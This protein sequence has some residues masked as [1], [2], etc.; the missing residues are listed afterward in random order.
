VFADGE[1]DRG[2]PDG[3]VEG[4]AGF[5]AKSFVVVMLNRGVEYRVSADGFPMG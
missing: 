1:G 3:G 5:D 2:G 4:G